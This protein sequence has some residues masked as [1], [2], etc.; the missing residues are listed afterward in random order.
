LVLCVIKKLL[1]QTLDR[2]QPLATDAAWASRGAKLR[3]PV[4]RDDLTVYRAG[5]QDGSRGRRTSS[6]HRT[7]S[8]RNFL[9]TIEENVA[10]DLEWSPD[11]GNHGTHQTAL[12]RQ[13]LLKRRRFHVHFTPTRSSWINMVERWFCDSPDGLAPKQVN[14]C[15]P[16]CNGSATVQPKSGAKP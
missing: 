15:V 7:I 4:A 3:F 10:T 1:I 2:T 11:T 14:G 12:I 8:F 13:G 6:T 16:G 5:Y 9:D